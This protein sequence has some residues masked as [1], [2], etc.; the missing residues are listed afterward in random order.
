MFGASSERLPKASSTNEETATPEVDSSQESASPE[1]EASAQDAAAMPSTSKTEG[2]PEGKPKSTS[3]PRRRGFRKPLP[4][5]LHRI[6]EIHEVD[7]TDRH[8]GCGAIKTRIGDENASRLEFVPAHCQVIVFKRV[9]YAC[10]SCEG[11]HDGGSVSAEEPSDA[12]A[13]AE[14]GRVVATPGE[15]ELPVARDARC[16]VPCHPGS[17]VP[18]PPSVRRPV[19]IIAPGPK[20]LI[21]KGIATASLLAHI[22]VSK[23][24]DSL[25]LYRQQKQFA[26][27]GVVIVRSTMTRWLLKVYRACI[28]LLEVLHKEVLAGRVIGADESPVQ[29][30][31][32]PNRAA[33]SESYMWTFRGGTEDKPAIQLVYTP[34][35][36]AEVAKTYLRDYQGAVQTDG[37]GGY[38]F[39]DKTKGIVHLG[40]IAHS[41]RKFVD[42]LKALGK[43]WKKKLRGV[44]GEAILTIR[45]LYA[46]ERQADCGQMTEEERFSLRQEKAKP[47]MDSLHEMLLKAQS[48]ALPASKLGEAISYTLNQWPRLVRYLEAGHYR[49][50]NNLVENVFRLFAVGRRNWLFCYSQEGAKASACFY[51]LILTAKANN[52]DP[53]WYLKALFERLPY[54]QS[55]ADYRALLP[56]YIDRALLAP[57]RA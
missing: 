44:A 3:P 38:D 53:F 45:E 28:P 35:R 40:C 27:I 31:K 33:T 4:A 29:V 56:Q 16:S 9:K 46:L 21:P 13:A 12:S 49:I 57:K 10:R 50:D 51:S 26:R 23:F 18:A 48:K 41:R 25:P 39:L 17:G 6:V 8:C 42:V 43:D 15:G 37:Y 11:V 54:A 47:L 22:I 7:E 30:I 52:L 24:L 20:H 19:V 55:E 34:T 36:S 32:E 14:L 2:K 5:E 1:R